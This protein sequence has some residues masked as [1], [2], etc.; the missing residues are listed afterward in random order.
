MAYVTNLPD[1]Y[2]DPETV[3]IGRNIELLEQA[4]RNKSYVTI[5]DD[6]AVTPT[7]AN[8]AFVV[9]AAYR[10]SQQGIKQALSRTIT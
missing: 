5:M 2:E 7:M 10:V 4:E 1:E 9:I 3:R 6:V 8:E